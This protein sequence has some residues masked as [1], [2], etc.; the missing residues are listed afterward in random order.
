MGKTKRT[1]AAIAVGILALL[2][3]G[4]AEVATATSATAD[5]GNACC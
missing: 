1:A 3:V 2:G 5:W 4:A